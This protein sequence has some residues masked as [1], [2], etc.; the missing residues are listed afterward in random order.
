MKIIDTNT[1]ETITEIVTNHSMSLDEV[2]DLIG[3]ERVD[4]PNAGDEDVI[5]DGKGYYYECLDM[6]W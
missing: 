2:L 6:V 4:D 3:A 5:I 1:N